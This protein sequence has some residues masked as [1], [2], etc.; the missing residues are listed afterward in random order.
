MICQI[1]IITHKSSV[2][3]NWS[4]RPGSKIT[5]F[6]LETKFWIFLANTDSWSG[7]SKHQRNALEGSL[8][9]AESHR[10]MSCTT[11]SQCC[12]GKED[13]A[14]SWRSDLLWFLQLY[15]S[16]FTL[17]LGRKLDIK[18]M[19]DSSAPYLFPVQLR[20]WAAAL[21]ISF[22]LP[23]SPV[24]TPS[25]CVSVHFAVFQFQPEFLISDFLWPSSVTFLCIAQPTLS[26][27]NPASQYS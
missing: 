20:T 13:V 8:Q 17:C 16:M 15:A 23:P 26:K 24:L 25:F 11:L 18:S 14:E 2:V 9:T 19:S 22:S 27:Q 7:A 3:P 10:G 5:I 6:V 12:F 21:T 4:C 1:V